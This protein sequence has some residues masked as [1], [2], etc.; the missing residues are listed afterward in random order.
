VLPIYN[1]GRI[2]KISGSAYDNLNGFVILEGEV[3]E[4]HIRNIG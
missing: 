2:V 3:L 1:N 4:T